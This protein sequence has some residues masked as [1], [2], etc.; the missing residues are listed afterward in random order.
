MTTW[1]ENY[2][3]RAAL[4]LTP[5]TVPAFVSYG[6]SLFAGGGFHD[7]D[8][9]ISF[10][11]RHLAHRNLEIPDNFDD[12]FFTGLSTPV[13]QGLNTA[14]YTLIPGQHIDDTGSRLEVGIDAFC[15]K[16]LRALPRDLLY[17]S[18]GIPGVING[19]P[20][21]RSFTPVTASTVRAFIDCYAKL[22]RWVPKRRAAELQ[23]LSCSGDLA[24]VC[25]DAAATH[26]V[27]RDLELLT[28]YPVFRKTG[29]TTPGFADGAY[30]DVPPELTDLP[31][32]GDPHDVLTD[33][34]C[35]F[36]F[37]DDASRANFLSLLITPFM[38]PALQEP[39]PLFLVV[40]SLPGT[41]KSML[42][43]DVLGRVVLGRPTPAMQLPETETETEKRITETLLRGGTILNID[44]IR[45]SLDSAAIASVITSHTWY[46]RPL[47]RSPVELP[48]NFT[49]VGSGNNVRVT[50]EIARRVVPIVLQ[51]A[52]DSPYLRT[53]FTHP[54][55]AEYVA[56]RRPL[57]VST[58]IS[59]IRSWIAA[60]RKPG[61]VSMGS[62]ARW[63]SCVGGVMQHAG[64]SSWMQNWRSW[65]KRSTPESEDL[66]ALIHAW[67]LQ[68]AGTGQSA[69]ELWGLAKSIGVFLRCDK[70]SESSSIMSFSKTVL[71]RYEDAPVGQHVIRASWSNHTKFYRLELTT[72][73]TV[74]ITHATPDI[75]HTATEERTVEQEF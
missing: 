20:G 19:A 14:A 37:A 64:F 75:T 6:A 44:N 10:I 1:A 60:G 29:L 5:E 58:I 42:I 41:G 38:R 30:Y 8:S 63:T 72:H 4:G 35:D 2:L 36:P 65:C 43:A 69:K 59:M 40:A 61:T 62:F 50:G 54:H 23:Y 31:A 48:N 34:V 15:D 9:T 45:E 56:E 52:N 11:L 24:A 32:P 46:G 47:Y 67:Q 7:R 22:A 57:I 53:D 74:A 73:G 49:V 17:R 70:N 18:G 12:A 26:P 27:V 16:I 13:R 68:K 25:L 39:T 21:H 71:N 3:E 66:A 33:L 55:L 51:P 28:S